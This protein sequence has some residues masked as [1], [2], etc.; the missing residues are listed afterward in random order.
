MKKL[1]L[2]L[3]L[4]L[5]S[6]MGFSQTVAPDATKPY[7][8]FDQSYELQPVGSGNA[9]DVKIYYDNQGSSAIKALQFKFWYDKNVFA[10]P[11]ITYVGGEANNYFL[12]KVDEVEGSAIVTWVYTG[13][14][15]SFNIGKGA[16]FNVSL[17]FQS[18]F[19]NGTINPFSFTGATN[20][21]AYATLADGTDNVLGLQNY[22]GG[23]KEPSFEYTA[24]IKN[25]PTNPASDIPVILQKSSDGNAW[26]DV[27]TTKTDSNGE[28]KFTENLDQSY[29]KLRVKVA[30]GLDTTSALS[31]ADADMMAQIATGVQT[32]VGT[33]FYT[34]NPNRTNGITISDSY[35]VFSRLSQ[36]LTAYPNTPDVLF[37]TEDEY[38]QIVNST[39]DKSGT[40][41]GQVTFL[42]T[43]INNTTGAVYYIL[44]LGDVNGTGL[45]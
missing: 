26:V 18:S 22:G 34:G 32:A 2:V 7:L 41:P 24:T 9:T 20:Y 39:T 8:I 12:T 5:V 29:W 3:G 43:L 35:L 28:A 37:F 10:K 17:P 36:A 42:S 33:Q 45:N 30:E 25:S 11:T 31:T 21:P 13:A 16:L 6:I 38:N 44:V 27:K 15:A 4:V 14:N 1:L 19:K 40:I 23:F